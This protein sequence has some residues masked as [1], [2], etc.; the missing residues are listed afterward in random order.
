MPFI[1]YADEPSFNWVQH[2][3]QYESFAWQNDPPDP[4]D[5][6]II[7]ETAHRLNRIHGVPFDVTDATGVLPETL[8]ST[9][10]RT[11]LISRCLRRDFVDWPGNSITDWSVFATLFV[12]DEKDTRARVE[13]AVGI[14]CPNLNCVQPL[15]TV[16]LTQNSL[17]APRK[18]AITVEEILAAI[19]KACSLECFMQE[20]YT[21]LNIRPDWDDHEVDDLR[22]S[23]EILPDS[24]PCDLALLCFK[25]CKEVFLWWRFLYPKKAKDETTNAPHKALFY[26]D[27]DASQFTPNEPCNHS[28]PCT[29]ETDCACYHNSAHCQRNCRCSSSCKRRWRGCRCTKLQ[30]MTEKCT[31]RAESRECD[32]ELCLRCGCK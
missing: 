11:G 26:V 27:G 12:P 23:L 17:P 28:G 25:P 1:P 7:M 5:Q 20:P 18:P 29:A 22:L 31:C 2:V 9:S 6:A 24:T 32:P 3:N 15:C 10:G 14:F 30:C 13:S 16:H 8:I 4:D 21:D 19:S